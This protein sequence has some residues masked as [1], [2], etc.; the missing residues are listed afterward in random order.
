V[1]GHLQNPEDLVKLTEDDE[2]YRT[3]LEEAIRLAKLDI[4]PDKPCARKIRN[5]VKHFIKY[6]ETSIETYHREKMLKRRKKSKVWSTADINEL[7]DLLEH[8]PDKYLDEIQDHLL[9]VRGKLFLVS[10]IY[11]KMIDM[12]YTLRSA[13]EKSLQRDEE[14]RA[15]WRMFLTLHGTNAWKQLIF[16]DETH[17]CVKEM[18]RRRHWFLRGKGQPWYTGI[19]HGEGD[20]RDF[21]FVANYEVKTLIYCFILI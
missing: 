10:T 12:G 3:G 15:R 7:R 2:R 9:A 13:Y 14:E 6:G 5:W 21:R 18:R 17:K 16:I 11:R 19:F 4:A 1:I 20:S 8:H